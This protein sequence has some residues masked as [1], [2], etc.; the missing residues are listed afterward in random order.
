MSAPIIEREHP[1]DRSA[2]EALLAG[3]GLPLAGL[4]GPGVRILVAREDDRVIGCAAVETFG[5]ACILRSL[6]IAPDR[7]G[8]GV[9][10]LLIDALLAEAR[11]TGC[12]EAYLLTKNVQNLAS[13]YG[14]E[15]IPR[16]K[17][18]P[19]AL[20]SPEFGLGCCATAKVMRRP[21]R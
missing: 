1:A 11:R 14:F 7:R 21:L 8:S 17:V 9:V 2:V 19:A 5:D 13:R 16:E 10:R 4:E 6:A 20:A 18:S 15:A 12:S 3:S